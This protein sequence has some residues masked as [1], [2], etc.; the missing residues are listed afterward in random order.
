MPF[1]QEEIKPCASWMLPHISKMHTNV[2]T[3]L[4]FKN[5][6]QT[7]SILDRWWSH[8]EFD[9]V[10]FSLTSRVWDVLK[11]PPIQ[12]RSKDYLTQNKI[13]FWHKVSDFHFSMNWPPSW[14]RSNFSY[15]TNEKS[16]FDYNMDLNNTNN[17]NDTTNKQK[18]SKFTLVTLFCHRWHSESSK[19]LKTRHTQLFPLRVLSSPPHCS[20]HYFW[21]L[22]YACFH[23]KSSLNQG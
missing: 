6:T 5:F 17:S 13:F 23:C 8:P 11:W 15:C 20:V 21:L 10:E 19:W 9:N 4:N 7:K 16:Y 12:R 22:L 1:K 18:I 3:P 14:T 2:C